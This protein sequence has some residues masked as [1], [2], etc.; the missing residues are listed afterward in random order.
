LLAGRLNRISLSAHSSSE[1]QASKPV[2]ARTVGVIVID[3]PVFE[4]MYSFP[5]RVRDLITP[6]YAGSTSKA[7]LTITF[8]RSKCAVLLSMEATRN[9][10]AGSPHTAEENLRRCEGR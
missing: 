5:K 7:T 10:F 9:F 3:D 6:E 8:R 1:D 4:Q 2:R